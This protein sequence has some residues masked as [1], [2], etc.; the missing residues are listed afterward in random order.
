M[1][2]SVDNLWYTTVVHNGLSD[3][4]CLILA[5][6]QTL[7]LAIKERSKTQHK[8]VRRIMLFLWFHR[9]IDPHLYI[10]FLPLLF[11]IPPSGKK[12]YREKR[13]FLTF[14]AA[15]IFFSSSFPF[16]FFIFCHDGAVLLQTKYFLEFF[17]EIV[18]HGTMYICSCPYRRYWSTSCWILSERVLFM[19]WE[20][21]GSWQLAK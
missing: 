18:I 17:C 12:L 4:G 19:K 8:F 21:F 13:K 7:V 3:A 10:S 2:L 20:E 14:L 15:T 1:R 6:L 11:Q 5:H 16:V 9:F